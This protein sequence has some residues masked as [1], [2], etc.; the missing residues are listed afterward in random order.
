MGHQ[1]GRQRPWSLPATTHPLS[2]CSSEP[3]AWR[4][5]SHDHTAPTQAG[6]HTPCSAVSRGDSKEHKWLRMVST[7]GTQ[8]SGAPRVSLSTGTGKQLSGDGEQ[9]SA[10]P[11]LECRDPPTEEFQAK[12]Q[13][14]GVRQQNSVKILKAEP[15]TPTL[16]SGPNHSTPQGFTSQPPSAG[17][18]GA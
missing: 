2:C 9:M 5:C 10:A 17:I 4:P 1:R 16:L 6:R 18:Q 3:P 13:Q 8:H 14:V 15:Q 12:L 11:R 7:E